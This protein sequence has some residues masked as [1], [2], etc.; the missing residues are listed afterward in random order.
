MQGQQRDSDHYYATPTECDKCRD[1]SYLKWVED[2]C[3]HACRCKNLCGFGSL[4]QQFSSL[5]SEAET[6]KGEKRKRD[7]EDEDDEDDDEDD[8]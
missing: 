5:P 2:Y 7:P 8:D 4:S 3:I 1:C 6:G